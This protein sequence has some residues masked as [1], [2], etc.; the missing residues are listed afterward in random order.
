LFFF[1]D[2]HTCVTSRRFLSLTGR[3]GR[4]CESVSDGGPLRG[5]GWEL[6]YDGVVA[7]VV[8]VVE[9]GV[10]FGRWEGFGFYPDYTGRWRDFV[11]ARYEDW[12]AGAV[13]LWVHAR[14]EVGG[15]KPAAS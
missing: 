7:L 3:I 2:A 11:P 4:S 1:L 12:R 10:E 13:M 8:K 15:L 5:V 9:S 14:G 6:D